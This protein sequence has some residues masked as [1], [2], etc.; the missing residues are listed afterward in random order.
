MWTFHIQVN[1]AEFICAP[2][3]DSIFPI[4]SSPFSDQLYALESLNI[5]QSR[6]QMMIMMMI[7]M[8]MMHDDDD[9]DDYDG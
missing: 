7:M 1:T 9:D 5:S 6:P 2:L 8:A 4:S 3:E